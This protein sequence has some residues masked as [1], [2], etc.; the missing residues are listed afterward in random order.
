MNAQA[1]QAAKR[2]ET[3][4]RNCDRW[5][6]AFDG[7]WFATQAQL[8]AADARF[9]AWNARGEEAARD[10]DAAVGTRGWSWHAG[11]SRVV[12][13]NQTETN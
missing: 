2:F 3:A 11:L 4:A 6:H 1:K 5:A 12:F 10:L 8:N 9:A 13:T 7:D